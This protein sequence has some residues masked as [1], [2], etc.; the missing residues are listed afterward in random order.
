MQSEAYRLSPPQRHIWLLQQSQQQ[1]SPYRVQCVATV[2]GEI[3]AEILKSAITSVIKRRDVLRATFCLT[4]AGP[5]QVINHGA[6][7]YFAEHDLS[8]LNP[9]AQESAIEQLFETTKQQPFH[10]DH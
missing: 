6:G 2:R 8:G 10:L 9:Q 5:L 7:F 1:R 3:D 4:D